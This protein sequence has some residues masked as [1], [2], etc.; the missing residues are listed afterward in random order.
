[1]F[2]F[3]MCCTSALHCVYTYCCGVC[4]PLLFVIVLIYSLSRDYKC[5]L[6]EATIWYSASNGDNILTAQETF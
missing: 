5:K 2:Y 3:L 1:M 6:A 4:Y